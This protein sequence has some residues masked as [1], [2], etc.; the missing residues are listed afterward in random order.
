MATF[1][2]TITRERLAAAQFVM[3]IDAD[4]ALEATG[5]TTINDLP[6]STRAE[7]AA[8][9]ENFA[10]QVRNGTVRSGSRSSGH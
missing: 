4:G 10:S 8:T 7:I 5:K 1:M 3:I 6:A 2:M 9:L